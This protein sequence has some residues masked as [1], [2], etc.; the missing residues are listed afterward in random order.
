MANSREAQLKWDITKDM[1]ARS[2]QAGAVDGYD[3]EMEDFAELELTHY[4]LTKQEQRR[5]RLEDA[6]VT[7][8]LSQSGRWAHAS[9]TTPEKQRRDFYISVFGA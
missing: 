4:H 9:P 1:T 8:A 7:T 2:W 6:E 5:G 3:R